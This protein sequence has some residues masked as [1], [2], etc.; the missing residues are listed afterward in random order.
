M[1]LKKLF[2]SLTVAIL[3]MLVFAGSSLA[4]TTYYVNGV[5]GNDSWTGTAATFQSGNVGPKKTIQAMLDASAVVNTDV[6]EIAGGTYDETVTLT[7]RVELNEN[8]GAVFITNLVL[9]TA[10]TTD[11]KIN[12]TGAANDMTING[13]L[14]I[15]SGDYNITA[16]RL[17]LVAAGTLVL[18]FN[19]ATYTGLDNQL[20]AVAAGYTLTYSNASA[21]A[22]IANDFI[23]D[24]NP[25]NVTFAGSAAVTLPAALTA[26]GN[27]TINSGASVVLGAND[28]T[29]PGNFTNNGSY[30]G[31]G[32]VDMTG[33]A[34]TVSGSGNFMNL[35]LN[36]A[37]GEFEVGS[38]LTFVNIDQATASLLDLNDGILDL[39]NFNIETPG[40]VT[41]G[42]AYD[43]GG[44]IKSTGATTGGK[45]IF[46]GTT[47][48]IGN[49]NF[50]LG[51]AVSLNYLTINKP[52]GSTVTIPAGPNA[53][54]V[55]TQ[56]DFSS[57]IF[58][59]N[60]NTVSLA[61]GHGSTAAIGGNIN[62]TT[63]TFS[64]LATN[65]LTVSGAGQINVAFTVNGG[66]A[67]TYTF[68]Q[69]TTIGNNLIVTNGLMT[70]QSLQLINGSVTVSNASELTMNTQA[71]S[72]TN[73][74]A[75]NNTAQVKGTGN[76]T[77]QG[78]IAVATGAKINKTAG[79]VSSAGTF[80][81]TGAATLTAAGAS[82]TVAGGNF[83]SG[84]GTIT[85]TG[86]LTV[87][88]NIALGAQTVNV[89]GTISATGTFDDG[90]ATITTTAGGN[91]TAGTTLTLN[92]GND[93]IAG[94]VQSGTTLATGAGTL[95]VTGNLQSG[96]TMALAGGNITVTGSLIAGTTFT[97]GGG[98]L[99]VTAS[100][101]AGGTFT[102]GA[103]N[104]TVGGS[105][106][107]TASG[108]LVGAGGTLT[109]TGT[110]TIA[111]NLSLGVGD[112]RFN[113]TGASS[114]AGIIITTADDADIA[115][116]GSES[117]YIGGDVTVAGNPGIQ[118]T[119]DVWMVF[120]GAVTLTN[121][122]VANRIVD[123]DA[124]VAKTFTITFKK[125][126]TAFSLLLDNTATINLTFD[127]STSL[128]VS[129][130]TNISMANTAAAVVTINING[131]LATNYHTVAVSGNILFTGNPVIGVAGA[132]A[133]GRV[134]MNGSGDL[135]AAIQTI[136]LANAEAI[137]NVEIA[138]TGTDSLPLANGVGGAAVNEVNESVRVLTSA[139]TVTNLYLTSNGLD[140]DNVTIANPGTIYRNAGFINAQGTYAAGVKNIIYTNTADLTAGPELTGN[141]TENNISLT[142]SAKVTLTAAEP[143]TGVLTINAGNTLDAVTFDVTITNTAATT[144]ATINGTF[145][146]TTGSLIDL[147]NTA[148]VAHT[149]T[150]TGTVS[151]FHASTFDGAGDVY[152]FSIANVSGSLTTSGAGAN[153]TFNMTTSGPSTVGGN[154]LLSNDVISLAKALTATGNLSVTAG[155]SFTATGLAINTAG[156]ITKA[157]AGTWTSGAV[158]MTGTNKTFTHTNGDITIAGNL[159]V[160]GDYTQAA[161]ALTLTTNGVGSVT[162]N[163][164]WAQAALTLS[165]TGN[166][167]VNGSFT[168]FG[169]GAGSVVFPNASTSSLVLR[170]AVT[171]SANNE[172][173]TFNTGSGRIRFAGTVAQTLSILT[174][175][176]LTVG[177]V[178]LNNAAGL[179]VSGAGAT[180]AVAN[181]LLTSGTLT[182]NGLL[183]M[184]TGTDR[185]IRDAGS[186]SAFAAAGPNQ[187]EYIGTADQTTGFELPSTITQVIANATT[188]NPSYT[189]DKNVTILTGGVLNL[190]R[191]TLVA[192]TNSLIVQNGCTITRAEGFLTGTPTYGT[193]QT[194]QYFNTISDLTTGSE[195]TNDGN[196]TTLLINA[197]TKNVILG[198]N[199]TVAGATNLTF[200]TL[201]LNGMTYTQS[202]NTFT[203]NGAITGTGTLA[204]TGGATLAGSV[205]AWPAVSSTGGAS[206]VTPT[207][208][209]PVTFASLSVSGTST[210]TLTAATVSGVTINGNFTVTSTAGAALTDNGE[211]ISFKGNFAKSGASTL[212]Q[213][214]TWTFNGTSAQTVTSNKAL[215][216]VTLNNSAGLTLGSDVI[217]SDG[218]TLTMSG[219]NIT[220]GSFVLQL[221]TT[222]AA[223]VTRTSGMIVGNC[224]AIMAT[225][226]AAAV[227]YLIPMGTGT[228]YRPITLGFATGANS[229]GNT[230]MVKIIHTDSAPTGTVGLPL[231]STP[232]IN[233][234][235][236]A[237]WT[238]GM[239][240]VATGLVF[241]SPVLQPTVTLGAGGFT[242][243]DI[244]KIRALYRL[245]N[246]G[247][248][249]QLP[250]TF[251]GSYY[252]VNG[253]AT[254][255]Q[256]GLSGWNLEPQQLFA[257]GYVS[258]FAVASVIADQNLTVGGTA[259]TKTI[260]TAP[261]VYT[262]AAG[263]LT[264]AVTSGTPA[265]ATATVVGGVLTVTAVSAGTSVITLTATDINGEML[266]TTFNANVNAAP[267]VASV[268][269]AAKT[270]AEG[271]TWVNTFSAT[272]QGTITLSK[273]S[274]PAW[275][276]F[277]P[278][279]GKLTMM[280]TFADAGTGVFVIR[281]TSTNLLTTD[282]T[283]TV[284]VTGVN[285][286][287]TVTPAVAT[288]TVNYGAASTVLFTGADVDADA[289]T[290]T[291]APAVTPAYAGTIAIANVVNAVTVTMTPATADIGKV[292][293]VS[294]TANDGTLT[295]A[296]VT[297]VTV[298]ADLVGTPP[299]ARVKGDVTGDGGVPT[300]D[301]AVPVLSYVVGSGTLTP[302]QLWA[303]DVNGD[304]V[305][306]AYDAA[307]ILYKAIN[308]TFLAKQ[309]AAAGTVSFGKFTAEKG[310]F[311]LP[312]IVE[313]TMGVK[314]FYSE[315][316]LGSSV[317]FSGVNGRLPEGWV[318]ASK[319]ENGTL[320]IAMAGTTP[321][322]DGAVAYINL[323]LKD[324]DA[325]VSIQG[326]T[327]MNDQ[328]AGA[329]NAVQIREIPSE[330][331][332][333]QNYPNP[334]NPTTSIKYAISENA[335]VTLTIY[336]ILGQAVRTL[337]NA[338]Q[339]AGFY[340]T[341]W[342]GTNDFGGKVSSGIYI[343]R[344]TAGSFTSTVKMNLLK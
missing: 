136:T 217:I 48:T 306:G 14:T 205:A 82:T 134:K 131:S 165:Q 150:G 285:Q 292:F 40:S 176:P 113:G 21:A 156:T 161:G 101:S 115:T 129:Q 94:S 97:G 316:Q 162:G 117:L 52:T 173:F 255:I 299:A 123:L 313:N 335:R 80:T 153:G 223:I 237:F 311:T 151:N 326:S 268:D 293:T 109:V 65:D 281:A 60:D 59:I 321:L 265:V 56:L 23:A 98:T 263:T 204:L 222:A 144:V 84:T 12:V 64:V 61:A 47:G 266:S 187:V 66:V 10:S 247:N 189:L 146:S 336:N 195:F 212:A 42:A 308:G 25:G 118:P 337:V 183:T 122:T 238:V 120:N 319:I 342:D 88:G 57:G 219:G 258:T 208:N 267:V 17:D 76:I 197:P 252:D 338:E 202:G 272:G 191:G 44:A 135:N 2:A 9:N 327:I 305:V 215:N 296:G 155:T 213:T 328:V 269:G 20:D 126:V 141:G 96:T 58:Q 226:P 38:N 50:T 34:K 318:M 163:M 139:L 198:S 171:M 108:A 271:T 104:I 1:N 89:T 320:K 304:N 5:T 166:F 74:L 225:D 112:I 81:L 152:T 172:T 73:N 239:Y 249:W 309:V 75:V 102:V 224:N 158:T 192:S 261:A 29:V 233:K 297:A 36:N 211:A 119:N 68:T 203:N 277:T 39:N 275:G 19:P 262:G 116:A 27:V 310:T 188:G 234:L 332:L 242:Y 282:Y 303:A 62:G 105:L 339:E 121:G 157:G 3:F 147:L 270:M 32:K 85:L 78:T 200:G 235:S 259:Y 307:S 83:T 133:F 241:T 138:N 181:L 178:E 106:T 72:I 301:D 325:V 246:V 154:V 322:T 160:T 196:I 11:T 295:G 344:I 182:H 22:Y 256:S 199:V 168:G 184:N 206:V 100:A 185:I 280:P 279:D 294:V 194:L 41:I 167:T 180:F 250:T 207:V 92:G 13:T 45:L 190:S 214:G 231:T 257:V 175:N 236:P 69:L 331:S 18:S 317:E 145:T 164:T 179:T 315:V 329:L 324:K 334:F 53:L 244:T 111:G 87:T 218:S 124:A 341:K 287:P 37:G 278:A 177:R 43:N 314:S 302:A 91:L 264:Y 46:S 260:Q 298:A 77:V 143:M 103:G 273:V 286:A 125:A 312:I 232:A 28:I 63:G 159:T 26:T 333:S 67:K 7:K 110:G 251:V 253:N 6:I 16:G 288:Q 4:Q 86:P 220:T 90:G 130:F 24:A 274:G 227:S 343:Y 128:P 228:N 216:N 340:T 300:A 170:G 174:G 33:A 149:A 193:G 289:L 8:G 283:Y 31:A 95:A 49:V 107:T 229:A 140:G 93:V 254:V 243:G 284:T 291:L 221:G 99:A 148:N 245:T 186:L 137:L 114:V 71:V 248:T 35:R 51:Q 55:N 210:V 54:A 240:D 209:L 79:T 290:Y 132:Q 276:V 330:F 323:S 230:R 169:G 201:N 15:Q 127:E 142:G 70:T 30:S